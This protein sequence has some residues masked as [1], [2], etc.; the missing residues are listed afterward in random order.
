[1]MGVIGIQI[2]IFLG[3]SFAF[4][5]QIIHSL[6]RIQVRNMISKFIVEFSIIRHFFCII[7]VNTKYQILSYPSTLAHEIKYPV[8]LLQFDLNLQDFLSASEIKHIPKYP[9]ITKLTNEVISN[10]NFLHKDSEVKDINGSNFLTAGQNASQQGT[11]N[12]K[13]I[14]NHL[15]CTLKHTDYRITFPSNRDTDY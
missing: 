5:P 2:N 8:L 11:Q 9:A 4:I 15:K 7:N 10:K 3:Q 13:P 6:R 14:T 12:E 1:M